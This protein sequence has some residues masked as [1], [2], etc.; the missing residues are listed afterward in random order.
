MYFFKFDFLN[1]LLIKD[2]VILANPFLTHNSCI[3]TTL[4]PIFH[5]LIYCIS[6]S[7]TKRQILARR[8]RNRDLWRGLP[9]GL[10][11][12]AARA[13]APGHPRGAGRRVPRRRQ[14]R[15]LPPG[16]ARPQ[17]RH[18]LG[19]LGSREPA[20][21]TAGILLT[22]HYHHWNMPLNGISMRL[23]KLPIFLKIYLFVYCHRF[24]S[25]Y[26]RL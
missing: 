4:V 18:A 21:G 23:R 17:L 26:C 14:E 1:L 20:R 2:I 13:H 8:Q 9:A 16:R 22:H 11:P 5:I 25:K 3:G 24:A 19:V 12:G 15:E 7:R 6:N 10:P